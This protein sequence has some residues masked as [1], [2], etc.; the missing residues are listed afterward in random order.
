MIKLLESAS[1]LSLLA[2]SSPLF[3]SFWTAL[4][5]SAWLVGVT[6]LS[7]TLSSF[8]FWA[9][10]S[11]LSSLLEVLSS[12]LDLD[13]DLDSSW[14]TC[15]VRDWT[16][17]TWFVSTSLEMFSPSSKRLFSSVNWES[18]LDRLNKLSSSTFAIAAWSSLIAWTRGDLSTCFWAAGVL[19]LST[20]FDFSIRFSLGGTPSVSPVTP[21]FTFSVLAVTGDTG[22]VSALTAPLAKN[23][24]AATA[25]LAAPKW[26]FRIE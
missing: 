9:L 4:I 26:Y 6:A 22:K 8:V 3:S 19:S 12:V 18:W 25:T 24:N 23:I 11:A 16:R 14:R 15:S 2:V 20:S 1:N 7:D 10:E 21:A 5:S 17:F 13:L